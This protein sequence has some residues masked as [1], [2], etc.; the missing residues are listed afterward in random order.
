MSKKK[1]NILGVVFILSIA[2]VYFGLSAINATAL[3]TPDRNW[4]RL[5][6]LIAMLLS[7]VIVWGGVY[8]VF[9]KRYN[10][11]LHWFVFASVAVASTFKTVVR[12]FDGDLSIAYILLGVIVFYYLFKEEN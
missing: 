2:I 4:M 11:L 6:Q 9:K 12:L 10:V 1:R 5:Q 7:G 3:W 8:V